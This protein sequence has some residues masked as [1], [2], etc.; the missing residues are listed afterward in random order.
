MADQD[1]TLPA[2]IYLENFDELAEE[3]LPPGWTVTNQTDTVTPGDDLGDL[4][5]D[6]YKNW[7]VV[8]A[9]RLQGLKA[10]AFQMNPT[11]V[12]GESLSALA[13]GNLIYCESDVRDGN[14]VQ[15]LF[16][17]DYDL[18]GKTNV[19]AV[20]HSLYEQNQDNVN[21][22]E[23]SIDGGANWLPALYYL[24]SDSGQGGPDIILDALGNIDL[25]KTLNTARADQAL[26]KSYGSF[27]AAPIT[28]ETAVYIQGRINDDALDGKR[29]EFVRL[30]KA[31]NQK[32]VRF[33]FFQAGTGSWYWGIDEFG[34]YSLSEARITVAPYTLPNWG[35]NAQ[36]NLG[37]SVT[38]NVGVS[39]QAPLTYQWSH[40]GTEI[41]GATG[42]T[43]TI[44]NAKQ[45][46][47]GLYTVT[48]KN[49]AGQMTSDPGQVTVIAAPQIDT[50]PAGLLVSAGA[51]FTLSVA[52]SGPAPITYQWQ[53][54][55][56]NITGAT[57]SNYK[58]TAA[59]AA[60]GGVYD[61]VVTNPQGSVTSSNVTVKVFSGTIAQDL[62]VHLPFDKDANDTSGRNNNGSPES[63]TLADGTDPGL[64][65][66]AGSGSQL[67]GAGA[68][69]IK[70]GQA[71]NLGA[72]TDLSFGA[73]TDFTVSFWVKA[74]DANAW[75]GDPAFFSNKNWDSGSSQ[76]YVIAAQG[77]GAWK[78]N[79]KGD[80]AGRR[81][82][83]FPPIAD[84]TWHNITVS[85][86]RQGNASFFVDG[87]LKAT[88]PIAGDGDIDGFGLSTYIGQDGTGGYGFA[89][90]TG[91]HFKDIWID[92]FGLWRRVVTPQEI[93]SI[94]A[95]G[96]KGEDLTKASGEIPST[97]TV[98][99]AGPTNTTTTAGIA[100]SFTAKATGQG[101][102]TYQWKLNGKAITGATNATF[103][104]YNPQAADAGNY[105]VAVTGQGGT[106]ESTPG[107]LTVN[108]AA[109]SCT[110]S[111]K[112]LAYLKFDGNYSDASGAGINGT[113]V[114]SPTFEA[115]LLGQAVHVISDGTDAVNNYVTLGYPVGLK[116]GTND[117]SISFWTK[118]NSQNDDKPF[119]S[120][121]DWNSGSNPGFA[122]AT[123]GDGLKWNFRDHD[124]S[125]GR[126]DSPHVAPQLL[127]HNW[128]HVVIAF[129]RASTASTYVDGVLVD[130]SNVAP[131]AGKPV[132]SVDTDD[133]NL[134][135]NIGQDGT[136]AYTDGTSGAAVDL[137]MD[138]VAIWGRQLSGA[139]V[140]CITSS[141]RSGKDLST[142]T[143]GSSGPKITGVEHAGANLFIH[144][145]SGNFQLQKKSSLG[146]PGWTDVGAPSSS[147]SFTVPVDGKS[148]FFRVKQL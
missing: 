57:N 102:L 30:P 75:T 106:V 20:F 78:W 47:G 43:L 98:I 99:T 7:V 74:A 39:G 53:K 29:I 94:Y 122:I 147:G 73:D 140:V 113:A 50:Q 13:T 9:D 141:G 26:G 137:L 138:D 67:V 42:P 79:W 17:S 116:V 104:I 66:Y 124:K 27:F 92:D 101:A 36:V 89:N 22:M 21:G 63:Q 126:R 125:S 1:V 107:N 123:E 37:G 18:T 65:A 41:A 130:S 55:Q 93:A 119:I 32:K 90:D 12:N 19:F 31:D 45:T 15:Y 46:D 132:V 77:S 70:D 144:V 62:V 54:D 59:A 24:Q 25:D 61:V 131:D 143:G 111:D 114:G 3:A 134:K 145:G 129:A 105:T 84:N 146:D 120:N 34:I 83:G 135:W 49:S 8:S 148:G 16:T 28:P 4:K 95:H 115:G 60:D 51:P 133:L 11:T 109:A 58:V 56:Q 118:I 97:P 71:I 80:S 96:L 23:Y 103:A 121:K 110:L 38:F 136:G 108:A 40:D 33:R 14:Q 85:H 100:V 68:L 48:V 139:E 82:V 6:A 128:H 91:A 81:D 10:A 112:L 88:Q 44:G 2:P 69:H 142:L 117:F 76:G 127:D 86:D 52:A 35:H 5:S 87:V 72:P 64:P